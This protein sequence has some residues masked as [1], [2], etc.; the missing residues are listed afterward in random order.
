MA[1]KERSHAGSD[2][3]EATQWRF[4]EGRAIGEL[5]RVFL[6]EGISLQ[7]SPPSESTRAIA[8]G[9]Q[10]LFEPTICANGLVARA[11][12]L[13]RVQGGWRLVEVKSGKIPENGKPKQEY[14]DDAAYTLLVAQQASIN[15]SEVSLVLLSRTHRRGSDD[16]ILERL[17]ITV[18]AMKRS[19]EYHA[20]AAEVVSDLIGPTQPPA[21]LS[22]ACKDC[23]YFAESCIGVGVEDSVLRIPRLSAKKLA[24]LAPLERIAELPVNVDLTA[25]QRTAVEVIRSRGY[26]RN[27]SILADLARVQ[28]PA[29]YLDFETIMPALPWFDGDFAY[30][31]IPMQYSIHLCDRAG[32]VSEHFEYL[33]PFDSDWR[34]DLVERLLDDLKD[35]GSIVVYSSYEK[36]QLSAMAVRFPD[37]ADRIAGVLLR[38]FDLEPFFKGGYIHHGFAGSSSIKHVLPAIVPELSYRGMAVGNGSDAAA[39]F[40]R[41]RE[42][43][44]DRSV[45][46]SKRRALLDYCNLDTL[47]M[48]KLHSALEAIRL[49]N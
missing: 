33:A 49:Q 23:Q 46:E 2:L 19:A 28:W 44:I 5:A 37:L 26:S 15:V 27:A 22:L 11:D 43:L 40:C 36:T 35:A 4:H 14:V 8:E 6:G 38:I 13:E 1:F 29:F 48:V 16:A 18:E 12:A 3:D 32:E 17:D 31:T 47:A 9:A 45:H 20:I 7:N 39:V 34:R 30:T 25:N 24:D 21:R 41:M 10:R 42:G